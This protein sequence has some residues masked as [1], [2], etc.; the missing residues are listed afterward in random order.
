M[1]QSVYFLNWPFNK[2]TLFIKNTQ[3]FQEIGM[4]IS[5]S[6]G[7]FYSKMAKLYAILS[8]MNPK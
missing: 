8:K 7:D 1:K 2:L 3:R 6:L 4:V 5:F